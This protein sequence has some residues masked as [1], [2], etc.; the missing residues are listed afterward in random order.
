MNGEIDRQSVEMDGE[1][2]IESDRLMNL[3]TDRK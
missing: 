3:E 2:D 1:I